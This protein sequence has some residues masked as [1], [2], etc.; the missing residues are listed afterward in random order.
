M[1][2][3][4]QVECLKCGDKPFSQHRHQ[5][6][7]CECGSIAVDGGT[8]YLRR[9]GNLNAYKDISIEWDGD[10]MTSIDDA[11]EW[12][13]VN[14]RNDFGRMCAIA[15][16]MRDAGYKVVKDEDETPTFWTIMRDRF[17]NGFRGYGGIK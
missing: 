15:R 4:N 13:L 2:L 10:L 5:M 11:I 12:A 14:N 1:I 6:K 16:Y 17:R 8:S 9:V 3:S 7:A